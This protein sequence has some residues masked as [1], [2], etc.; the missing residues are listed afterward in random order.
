MR[1]ALLIAGR[2]LAAYL[3]SPLGLVIAAVML[4]IDGIYFYAFALGDG[5]HLSAEVLRLF[6]EGASGTT[7]VASLVLSM[8]LFAGERE[9]GTLV[10][11][12]TAPI[13]DAEIVVGKFFA[14]FA[15]ITLITASTIYMPLLIFVHGKVSTGHI[16]VGYSGILLLGAATL[17]IGLFGS[18]L[19]KSQI[20]AVIL[21]AAILGTM[22]LLWM[23]ALKTDPPLNTFLSWLAIHDKRQHPFTEGTLKLE[24]VVFYVAVTYFFLLSAT[25]TLE[26]RRWR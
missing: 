7:M 1:T 5:S 15:L 18:S 9:A 13:R 20:V 6:F 12:N 19:A 25:K 26:A 22:L 4:L 17:A 11:L 3:R 14:A 10:L 21:G 8:R 24:N 2:E 16:L 23:I